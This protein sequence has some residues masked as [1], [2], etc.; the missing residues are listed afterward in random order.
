MGG[1]QK[2]NPNTQQYIPM[3]NTLQFLTAKKSYSILLFFALNK[4]Q[5]LQ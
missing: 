1:V 5:G 3:E 2:I 4:F